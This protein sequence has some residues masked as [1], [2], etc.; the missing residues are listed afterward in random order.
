[1]MTSPLWLR[2]EEPIPDFTILEP[3]ST[4]DELPGLTLR[5]N[6]LNMDDVKDESDDEECDD[7]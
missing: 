5:M 1:M 2:D 7:Y 6:G 3:K 4:K